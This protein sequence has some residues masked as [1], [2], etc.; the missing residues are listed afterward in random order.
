[1]NEISFYETKVCVDESRDE[2]RVNATGMQK[3]I[4]T[5]LFPALRIRNFMQKAP[6]AL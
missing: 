5:H 4:P 2:S 3:W 1:L 6:H